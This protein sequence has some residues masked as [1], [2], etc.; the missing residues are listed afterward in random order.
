VSDVRRFADDVGGDP[1]Y[2][3]VMLR[4]TLPR[5]VIASAVLAA[6]L[7]A[8]TPA[9]ASTALPKALTEGTPQFAVR[10]AQIGFTGDGSGYVGGPRTSSSHF[11]RISWRSW[12]TRSAHG[13][14]RV[15]INDCEPSCAGGTF[16]PYRVS[17]TLASPSAGRFRRLTL[18]YRHAGRAVTDVRRIERHGSYWSYAIVGS[19]S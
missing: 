14:G 12:T 11:G 8:A 6:S 17:V 1:A 3:P 19:G 2:V 15:W 13:T 16:H 10:P 7:A 4:T 9:G 5:P 18:H